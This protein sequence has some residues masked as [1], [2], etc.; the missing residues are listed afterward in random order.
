MGVDSIALP[1]EKMATSYSNDCQ[2]QGQLFQQERLC[3][4]HDVL[5]TENA[6]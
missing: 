1:A 2:L 5:T 3:Q 4:L 6:L